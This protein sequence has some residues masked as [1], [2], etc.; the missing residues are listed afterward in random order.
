MNENEV[1]K[2]VLDAAFKVHTILGPGL[3]ESAYEKSLKY[4]LERRGL[5]VEQQIKVPI[6]Y[7]GLSSTRASWPTSSWKGL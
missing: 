5:A 7:E 2:V 3:L 1:S 6:T 4:E